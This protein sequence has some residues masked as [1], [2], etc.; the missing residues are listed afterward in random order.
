MSAPDAAEAASLDDLLRRWAATTP[1]ALALA[2][3]VD[4]LEWSFSGL[5][6]EVSRVAARL[7]AF[8]LGARASI[9]VAGAA[10]PHTLVAALAAMRAGLRTGLAPL[11][12]GVDGLAAACAACGASALIGAGGH[13]FGEVPV[14]LATTAAQSPKVRLV[15]SCGTDAAVS[16]INLDEAGDSA[17]VDPAPEILPPETF[18][19]GPA[20]LTP[21]AHS[22]RKLCASALDLRRAR[23]AGDNA[24]VLSTLAPVTLAG[25][26]S[27]PAAAWLSGRALWLHGPFESR[28]FAGMLARAGR[29]HVVAPAAAAVLCDADA[30]ASLT[31]LHRHADNARL[32]PAQPPLRWQSGTP[33]QIDLHAFGER[34]VL[35]IARFV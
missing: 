10:S 7:H 20:G 33:R 29:A 5:D 23:P 8:E 35:A 32:P 27:G 28:A 31:L 24:P 6:A 2:G 19:P 16:V 18:A 11:S 17:A 30:A 34:Q 12:F 22:A 9:L 15:A 25:L 1:D 14:V 4:Q 3:A 26:V 13:E 21:V